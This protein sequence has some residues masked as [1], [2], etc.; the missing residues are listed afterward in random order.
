MSTEAEA[1]VTIFWIVNLTTLLCGLLGG[2][3]ICKGVDAIGRRLERAAN[4]RALGIDPRDV[5]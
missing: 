2:W 1:V 4:R 5:L 3:V